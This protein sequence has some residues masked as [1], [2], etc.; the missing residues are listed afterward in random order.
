[1]NTEWITLTANDGHELD[2]FSVTANDP[3]GNIVVI[4]EIFGITDHIQAVCQKF[5]TNGYNVVGC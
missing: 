5:A 4:Q 2:A 3:I 1:M